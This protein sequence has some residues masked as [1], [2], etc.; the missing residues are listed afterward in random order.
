[1]KSMSGTEVAKL[2]ID[3]NDRSIKTKNRFKIFLTKLSRSKTGSIG[4]LIVLTLFVM[5]IFAPWIA[6]YNP[7]KIDTTQMLVPPFW[8]DGGSMAH[9]LGTDNLGRDILSRIIYGS[10]IS[11]VVGILSVLVAGAIGVVFGLISGYYGGMVDNIIMRLV[12]AFLSVPT[13]LLYRISDCAG[14]GNP[15]IGHCNRCNKLGAL[16]KDDS[17]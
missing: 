9:I 11:L 16:R 17:Q 13:I 2:P 7:G 8:S 15:D 14:S 6:P 12:D 1:M 4:L 10:R 3:K 5:A